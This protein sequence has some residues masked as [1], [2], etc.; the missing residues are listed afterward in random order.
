MCDSVRKGPCFL[1]SSRL[2]HVAD[3][4]A[5]LSSTFK[6]SQK[7]PALFS[8]PSTKKTSLRKKCPKNASFFQ[9]FM[10]NNDVFGFFSPNK[11]RKS[12][13]IVAMKDGG[14]EAMEISSYTNSALL[15]VAHEMFDRK[16]LL[17]CRRK[18]VSG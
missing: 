6:I 9:L 16:T 1:Y 5:K 10:E 3:H 8:T 11:L 4:R 13:K 2:L 14:K 15:V 12:H 18:L 17:G 7:T